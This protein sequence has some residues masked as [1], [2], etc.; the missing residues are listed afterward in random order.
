MTVELP[1]G[2]AN[3]DV[4]LAD[5]ILALNEAGPPPSS[6]VRGTRARPVIEKHRENLSACRQD[7]SASF[8]C[9]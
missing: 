4:D 3:I 2:T 6:V 7:E 5:A 8:H 1:S 9:T